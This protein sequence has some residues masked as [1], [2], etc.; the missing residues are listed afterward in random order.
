MRELAKVSISLWPRPLKYPPLSKHS[1]RLQGLGDEQACSLLGCYGN[2]AEARSSAE[3]KE[4]PLCG[5]GWS[6]GC[7]L[8]KWGGGKVTTRCK[9]R[10]ARLSRSYANRGGGPS[11]SSSSSDCST[12]LPK[13]ATLARPEGGRLIGFG[14]LGVDLISHMHTM[15][16]QGGP[17]KSRRLVRSR[18]RR[19]ELRLE[20]PTDQAERNSLAC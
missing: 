11:A 6:P 7:C 12:C 15:P 18:K 8:E 19:C 2:C 16:S 13:Q 20:L 1:L 9:N 14:K 5:L 10:G 17:S 3:R 4:G